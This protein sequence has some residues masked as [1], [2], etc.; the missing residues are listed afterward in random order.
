MPPDQ[1]APKQ[2]RF[3]LFAFLALVGLVLIAGDLFD[4][5]QG[6]GAVP[7]S[8]FLTLVDQGRI[9]E[10]VMSPERITGSYKEPGTGKPHEFVTTR[11]EDPDLVK[12][13]KSQNVKFSGTREG[14]MLLGLVSWF[15]P[16]FFL[17]LIWS[18][19]MRRAGGLP[20]GGGFLSLGKSKAKIYVE[21]NLK[22]RFE[23]VAG[24]DEAK[25]ELREIVNYLKAP[26][27]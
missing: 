19:V 20:Q 17:M 15:L 6:G 14:G 9:S 21:T 16:F 4:F 8:Q 22:T 13:L 18:W 24:V 12:R 3:G 26:D 1:A 11:V 10:V 2:P 25:E 5:R 23:D 27:R 7:Y